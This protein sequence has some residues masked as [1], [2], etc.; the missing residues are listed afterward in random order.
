MKLNLRVLYN[1][2]LKERLI[3]AVTIL[4][5]V[6]YAIYILIIPPALFH[7]KIAK[8]QFLV[9]RNLIR[10]REEKTKNLLQFEKNFQS[11]Q[12]KMSEQQSL[13]FT[14]EEA[15]DFLKNLES[16][17]IET[18]N[19]LKELR[20]Q[21][22]EIVCNSHL[23]KGRPVCYKKSI[24]K[25]T[26]QGKYDTFIDYFREL[27]AHDK[28][29]EVEQVNIKHIGGDSLRLEAKFLLSIYIVTGL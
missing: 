20:P 17:A 7:Y 18:G 4:S 24:V 16:L 8:R 13:F 3:I 26:A 27:T 9:Q 12:L 23:G 15:G 5:I 1:L 28:V 14:E 21:G 25:L 10:S 19:D 29:L 6:G 2:N 22:V 11:L